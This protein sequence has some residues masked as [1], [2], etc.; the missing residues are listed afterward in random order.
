M[1]NIIEY[2]ENK[3]DNRIFHSINTN[4]I[5]III[6]IVIIIQILIK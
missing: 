5:D 2:I 4:I 3:D 1:K 6:L